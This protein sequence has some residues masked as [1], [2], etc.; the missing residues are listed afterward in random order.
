MELS[1]AVSAG[2]PVQRI[3]EN[4]VAKAKSPKLGGDLPSRGNFS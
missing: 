2:I 3:E 1:D 4:T